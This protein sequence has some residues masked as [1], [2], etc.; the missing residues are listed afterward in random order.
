[1]AKRN[2]P[3]QRTMNCQGGARAADAG[4]GGRRKD[5]QA[6]PVRGLRCSANARRAKA[7]CFRRDL[8]KWGEAVLVSETRRW[9]WARLSTRQSSDSSGLCNPAEPRPGRA[10][11]QWA[12]RCHE[13]HDNGTWRTARWARRLSEGALPT[14]RGTA[15][16][17]VLKGWIGLT[18]RQRK[19]TLEENVSEDRNENRHGV[20]RCGVRQV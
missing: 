6:G 15:A 14:G 11:G 12:Q 9:E 2:A 1:M 3:R 20:D 4:G 5:G 13:P 10:L 18:K 8:R 19:D 16:Q 17:P 7:G